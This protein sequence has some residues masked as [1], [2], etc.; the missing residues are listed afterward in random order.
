MRAVVGSS[1]ISHLTGQ[2][3][4]DRVNSNHRQRPA[5]QWTMSSTAHPNH[6]HA[7]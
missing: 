3:I 5:A 7:D 4:N 2:S 1:K 6:L